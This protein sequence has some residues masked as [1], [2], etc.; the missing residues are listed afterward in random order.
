MPTDKPKDNKISQGFFSRLAHLLGFNLSD[1]DEEIS[2]R[3]DLEDALKEYMSAEHIPVKERHMLMNIIRF[4]DMTVEDIMIR[5]ADIVALDVESSLDE[6]FQLFRSHPYS[7]LPVYKETLDNPIGVLHVKDLITMLSEEAGEEKKKFSLS[8]LQRNILFVPPAMLAIELLIRMQVSHI[9]MALVIDEYGGTDGLITLVDLIEQ[10]VGDMDDASD[11]T[12][13]MI[14]RTDGS[15]EVNAKILLE[16]LEEEFN[17][18]FSPQEEADTETDINTIADTIGG[19]IISL[20]GRV[21]TRG[22]HIIHPHAP[23]SFEILDADPRR[24]KRVLIHSRSS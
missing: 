23:Y 1:A 17:I 3:H 2:A 6:V 18:S 5:R 14:R 16:T 21:P 22:E 19:L 10:I 12:V 8:S 20:I 13:M 11:P 24:I 4:G 7:R 9:H 15:I